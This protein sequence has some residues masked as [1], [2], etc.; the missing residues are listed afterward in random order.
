MSLSQHLNIIEFATSFHLV[1]VVGFF[2]FRSLWIL[3]MTHTRLLFFHSQKDIERRLSNS[4]FVIHS[5][6]EENILH[7][8][9]QWEKC[10][11]CRTQFKCIHS[12][13]GISFI[14]SFIHSIICQ[15]QC[16]CNS[17][18]NWSHLIRLLLLSHMADCDCDRKFLFLFYC[19][20][21]FFVL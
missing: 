6:E 14:H 5:K 20:A 9:L 2:L 17:H 3:N 4:D 19:F 8:I 15:S 12:V 21:C 13:S 10:H 1:K 11:I 18:L 16:L 7:S